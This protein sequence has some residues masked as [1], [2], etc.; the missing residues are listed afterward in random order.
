MIFQVEAEF[1]IIFVFKVVDTGQMIHAAHAVKRAVGPVC[2][3]CHATHGRRA[4]VRIAVE[5]TAPV[6]A[7]IE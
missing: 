3:G 2:Y 4:A 5:R 7:G 1:I 6:E